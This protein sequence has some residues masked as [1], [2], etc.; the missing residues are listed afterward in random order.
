MNK[1]LNRRPLLMFLRCRSAYLPAGVTGW[2]L[3]WDGHYPDWPGG[4][5]LL[6]TSVTCP[7][8][9]GPMEYS[10]NDTNKTEENCHEN[11][12]RW[13]LILDETYFRGYTTYDCSVLAFPH[14]CISVTAYPCPHCDLPESRVPVIPLLL[15]S[16]KRY[17][18]NRA[19]WSVCVCPI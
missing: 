17:W 18:N 13:D 6:G 5:A 19:D 11:S 14:L 10:G 9:S 3:C 15:Y 7:S 12:F 8:R 4:G 2:R 16:L 1:A